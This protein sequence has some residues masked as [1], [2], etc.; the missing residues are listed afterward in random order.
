[1]TARR[2]PPRAYRDIGYAK[3]GQQNEECAP[4]LHCQGQS[5]ERDQD[6]RIG[7]VS[8]QAIRTLHHNPVILSHPDS[9][10]EESSQDRNRPLPNQNTQQH[11]KNSGIED[12]I[13][14]QPNTSIS[15]TQGDD[16][17]DENSE[18]NQGSRPTIPLHPCRSSPAKPWDQHRPEE[19][20]YDPD[21]VG[22][23]E[24]DESET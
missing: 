11:Q 20:A 16:D 4:G 9:Q 15:Q 18:D 8:D 1:P 22:G 6:S 13:R 17:R 24:Q 7:W 21:E 23:V 2:A 14:Q 12:P 5:D 19:F 10:R 3:D